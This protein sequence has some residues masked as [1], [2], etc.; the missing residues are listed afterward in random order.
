M[1]SLGFKL[2]AP[3]TPVG[4]GH[5]QTQAISYYPKATA[6]LGCRSACS[7]Q[8]RNRAHPRPPR[9]DKHETKGCYPFPITVDAKEKNNV[10]AM[11]EATRDCGR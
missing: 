2:Y 7:P 10:V 5:F 8:L 4:A 9:T 11:E 6:D 3:L 1:K